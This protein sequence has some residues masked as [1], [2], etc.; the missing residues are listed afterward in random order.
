[1]RDEANREI[2]N[3][4]NKKIEEVKHEEENNFNAPKEP[5][6]INKEVQEKKITKLRKEAFSSMYLLRN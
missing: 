4:E 2:A 3:K 5:N 1:M 6:I